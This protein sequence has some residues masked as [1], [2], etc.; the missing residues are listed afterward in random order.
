MYSTLLYSTLLCSPDV[1]CE[2]D[3]T[4]LTLGTGT[5]RFEVLALFFFHGDA[6]PLAVGTQAIPVPKGK[7]G[8]EKR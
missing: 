1:W 7:D 2:T 5:G 8:K 3:S 6:K 4:L